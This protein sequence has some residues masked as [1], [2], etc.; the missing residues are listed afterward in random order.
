MLL[1]K[2]SK[3]VILVARFFFSDTYGHPILWR[4]RLKSWMG[5]TGMN[6]K[7][8]ELESN[9]ALLQSGKLCRDGQMLKTQ[10]HEIP[11]LTQV[12]PFLYEKYVAT[13][14]LYN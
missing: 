11:T 6:I 5:H 10:T 8:K 12:S 1:F 9:F 4:L 3:V 13:F 2:M 7:V 14:Q